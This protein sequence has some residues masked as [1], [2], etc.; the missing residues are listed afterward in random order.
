VRY[1]GG[2]AILKS[3]LMPD[4][5]DMTMDDAMLACDQGLLHKIDTKMIVKTSN[6]KYKAKNAEKTIRHIGM[7]LNCGGCTG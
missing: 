3:E 2:Q 5:I 6:P 4:I 7:G 1:N